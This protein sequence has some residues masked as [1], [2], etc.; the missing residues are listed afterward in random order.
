M[1]SVRIADQSDWSRWDS[2]LLSQPNAW[3]Y[4]LFAWREAII[5]GYK[6]DPYYF[7]AEEADEI[8]GVLPVIH[9]KFPFITNELTALPYCDVGN[10]V[11][12]DEAFSVILDSFVELGKK[13]S[14]ETINLRGSLDIDYSATVPMTLEST[15]KVR[16][17]MNLP[18]SSDI[19]ISSYK[20]KL[21]SQIRKSEKNGVV[22]RWGSLDDIDNF[23]S[24]MSYNMRD[25][26]SPVH[27]RSWFHS[28]L[29]SFNKN[30]RLGLVELDGKTVGGCII[31][32]LNDKLCIPWASTLRKYN[33]LAPNMLLYWNVLKYACDNHFKTFDFGR[34][35]SMEGTYRF[36]AQWG[37]EASPLD[38]YTINIHAH[39]EKNSIGMD[40]KR[41]Y[42]E[43]VWRK[44][45]LIVTN[46]FGPKIRRY[47]S[48]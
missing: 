7:I 46:Y 28:V 37:A 31:L 18:D 40:S 11:G 24:V 42:F 15:N 30:A 29:N 41:A 33:H 19:L 26:G 6:H 9:L 23:Y 2:F 20:S 13:L 17:L 8:I 1:I 47:I 36:K 27:S 43:H 14:V 4:H 21:R 22:F 32:M 48:L 12:S 44:M 16:M 5:Q 39:V 35:S 25:L 38:W 45:P 3:P 10:Y 34:S